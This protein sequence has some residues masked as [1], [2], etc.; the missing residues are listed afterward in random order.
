MEPNTPQASPSEDKQPPKDAT[1]TQPQGAT[2]NEKVKKP[3]VFSGLIRPLR[4]YKDDVAQVLGKNK[5]SLIDVAAAEQM[6]R[7]KR[8]ELTDEQKQLQEEIEREGAKVRE[9][10]DKLEQERERWR[11][12]PEIQKSLRDASAPKASSQPAPAIPHN[13]PTGK[14]TQPAP[15]G[16]TPPTPPS[17]PNAQSAARRQS[18]LAEIK[19]SEERIRKAKEKLLENKQELARR[20]P[21]ELAPQPKASSRRTW[22]ILGVSV[23]LILVASGLSY[24]AYISFQNRGTVTPDSGVPT[25]VPVNSQREVVL[26][27]PIS[28]GILIDTLEHERDNL[29]SSLGSV[30]QLYP[31]RSVVEDTAPLS[32]AEFLSILTPTAPGRF[33][34]SLEP[35]FTFGFHNREK[36]EPFMVLKTSFFENA[37]AGVLEWETL[38]SADLAPLFGPPIDAISS[39]TQVGNSEIVTAEA[40]NSP[41][42]DLVVRNKDTRVLFD[43][44]ENIVLLYS[45]VDRETLIV[46]TN[47]D[48]FLEIFGRMSSGR[49][50]R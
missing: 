35:E 18:Q 14:P 11:T 13:L 41:F 28:R 19:T 4:T 20:M 24:F 15:V 30:T 10:R 17:A 29:N 39:R 5:T 1:P 21:T 22:I 37:F 33:T 12:Q 23:A 9:T 34:R 27:D 45:F 8:T 43:E 40:D 48:T 25:F 42:V 44:N 6:R 26:F 47:T 16:T 32:T 46:T 2:P 31:V 7:A 49:V 36:N 38:M 3:G 50:V